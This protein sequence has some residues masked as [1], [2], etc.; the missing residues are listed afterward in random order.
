[1]I[2]H[3]YKCIFVHIP[4]TAGTSIEKWIYGQSWWG[5]EKN[6]KHLLASQAKKAYEQYWNDYFK[7][8]IV[9][10]PWDRMVSCLKFNG[11]FKLDTNNGIIDL[12][13]Y[14]NLYSID[15][16]I[17]EHDHRFSKKEKL[18]SDKHIPNAIYGNILDEELDYIGKYE[19]LENA[20][21]YIKDRI[22]IRNDF[23]FNSHMNESKNRKNYKKYYD[24]GTKKEVK[25]MFLKDI[26]D[27]NYKF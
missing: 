20:V 19:D 17:L 11:Y 8:S 18:I 22:K 25:S 26:E 21:K 5:V 13:G 16:V 2:S 4:R 24:K 12:S 10:N 14:K 1:M 3:K 7:F 27:Y 23:D 6:T 9:R 15:N